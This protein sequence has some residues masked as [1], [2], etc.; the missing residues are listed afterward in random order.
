[1]LTAKRRLLLTQ[2]LTGR[3]CAPRLSPEA[4]EK[5]SSH[6]VSIRKEVSQIEQDSNERSSIP[7]TIRQLEAIIRISEA[8]AKLTLSPVV[9]EGNVDEAIRLFMAS[10]MDAVS[11]GTTTRKELV[12]EVNKIEAELKK[13]LPIGWS[14]SQ[15]TLT[16]DFVNN[17]GIFIK[18]PLTIAR[19]FSTCSRQGSHGNGK[20][21]SHS[22]PQ[23]EK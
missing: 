21:R 6:F 3:K 1:M 15:A 22:I 14:T 18:S 16:R 9:S 19:L 17:V 5:L 4:S 11:Q 23:P 7:I 12:D 13:R 10:T 8:L 20:A 2:T